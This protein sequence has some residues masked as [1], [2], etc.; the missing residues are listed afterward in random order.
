[1]QLDIPDFDKSIPERLY[2]FT[3]KVIQVETIAITLPNVPL[4]AS[5][6]SYNISIHSLYA[7][8]IGCKVLAISSCLVH[9]KLRQCT[10]KRL[11]NISR[12]SPEPLRGHHSLHMTSSKLDTRSFQILGRNIIEHNHKR[13]TQGML[14]AIMLVSAWHLVQVTNASTHYKRLI[15][16]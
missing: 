11:C 8:T 14:E 3:M 7:W 4:L 12:Q 6:S 5:N 15:R 13:T 1:M 9:I 10:H 2:M 16:T